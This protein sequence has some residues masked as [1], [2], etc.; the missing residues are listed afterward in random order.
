MFRFDNAW[1]HDEELFSVVRNSWQAFVGVD[2]MARKQSYIDE[3]HWWGAKKNSRLWE[4][5]NNLRRAIDHVREADPFDN[6]SYL[7][8]EWNNIMVQEDVRIR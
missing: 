4:R 6:C 5:K 1:L 7:N 3:L 8:R 2:L